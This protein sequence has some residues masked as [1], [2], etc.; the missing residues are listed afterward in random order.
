MTRGDGKRVS[1]ARPCLVCG[2]SDWC[3]YFGP[4]D[5][6]TAAICARTESAKPAGAAGWWHRLR[7]DDRRPARIIRRAVRMVETRDA[8]AVDFGQLVADCCAAVR[9]G[10]LQRLAESLGLTVESLQRLRVGWAAGHRAWSFPMSDAGGRIL[11]VRLRLPSGRKLSVRG[12]KEGLFIPTDLN[13]GGRLL[14]CEG[15]TD[16]AALLGLGLSAVGRPSCSGGVRLLVELV[17]QR[18]TADVVIVADGDGPGQRGAGNLA[19]VL[20]AYCPAV[21][22]IAPPVGIKDAR[23][24]KRRGATAAD[25]TAAIDAAPVRKLEIRAK[26]GRARR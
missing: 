15:P 6:P 13:A 12:G 26:A 2:R 17:K 7:D 21:R 24:W 16:T 19:A 3:I 25:V 9:S 18:R 1:K 11:G 4:D 5:A 8:G 14:V 10:D 23:E 22:I 20:M